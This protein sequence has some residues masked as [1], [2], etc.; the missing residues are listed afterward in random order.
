MTFT[1]PDLRDAGARAEA[2]GYTIVGYKDSTPHWAEAF[3]H[4]R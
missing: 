1:V 4:P 3:L 2:A